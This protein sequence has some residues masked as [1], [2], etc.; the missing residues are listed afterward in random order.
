MLQRRGVV[1]TGA[2]AVAEAEQHVGARRVV[3]VAGE[4]GPVG[5]LRLVGAAEAAQRGGDLNARPGIAWIGCSSGLEL[6]QRR[7]VV[8]TGASTVAK[9]KQ[10][11]ELGRV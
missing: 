6:L 11:M 4:D 8:A 5:G 2:D 7:G 1:A 10:C 9:A 3:G